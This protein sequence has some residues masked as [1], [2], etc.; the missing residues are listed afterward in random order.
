MIVNEGP[1]LILCGSLVFSVLLF[2]GAVV[3]FARRGIRSPLAWFLVAALFIQFGCGIAL[4]A[5]DR[6][7]GNRDLTPTIIGDCVFLSVVAAVALTCG[8]ALLALGL[9]F[10]KR[11]S[12]IG[13]EPAVG[14]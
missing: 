2:G 6:F 8:A 3:V 13:K 11:Q 9:H 10:R 7:F 14:D 5:F 1:L 12:R 4:I